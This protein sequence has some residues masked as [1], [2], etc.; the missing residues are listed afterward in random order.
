L[1][2]PFDRILPK[3]EFLRRQRAFSGR[4]VIAVGNSAHTTGL[5]TKSLLFRDSTEFTTIHPAINPMEWIAHDKAE[6]R[7]L[8]GIAQGRFVMG[9]GA[10]SLTDE[11]KG[12]GRFIEVADI[13]AERMGSIDAL[14]F[15]DGIASA[16]GGKVTIHALGRMSSPKLQSLV[17][18]AMDVFVVA[19]RMETFGQVA[20]EAQACGT[21]VW[22]FDVGGLPDAVFHG[23][24]G[25]LIP[26]ADTYG[27]ANSICLAANEGSLSLMGE[28]GARWVREKFTT[29][30]MAEAYLRIYE[31]SLAL[32]RSER[33]PT[34]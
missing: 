17:Y 22:A 21:P 14:V 4:R 34:V 1:K 31:Q 24:T 26:F 27:M 2:T 19:S 7:R 10:A 13:V 23:V 15:G 32:S 28:A 25:R 16:E 33:S 12:F 30:R 3:R 18:S 29:D 9:F 6:A 5:I 8:L 11:N 20:I